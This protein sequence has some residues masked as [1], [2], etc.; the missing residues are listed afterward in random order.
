M[1]KNV[2]VFYMVSIYT[3]IIKGYFWPP[4]PIFV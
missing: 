4:L 2:E 3:K 1:I